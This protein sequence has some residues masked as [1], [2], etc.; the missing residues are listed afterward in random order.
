MSRTLLWQPEQTMPVTKTEHEITW[1]WAG[2]T[3]RVGCDRSGA[4][5][6]ILLLPALSSISTR[7]EMRPLQQRLAS[8][9]TTTSVDWPGFGDWP[10]PPVDW[11]P[12]A[13]A[14]FLKYV[15]TDLVPKPFATIAAGHAACYVMAQSA[16]VPGSTGRLCLIAPTW[17]GPLPTMMGKRHTAFRRI[18]RAFDHQFVGPLLYTLNVNRF[19]VRAMARGHVYSDPNWLTGSR[20]AEKLAVTRAVGARHA[21][22]RFVAGELDFVRSRAEFLAL[23]GRIADT[24]LVVFADGTPSRSKAEMEALAALP[25]VRLSRIVSGKLAVH[26]E[27]PDDVTN[28]IGPFLRSDRLE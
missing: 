14:A 22:V 17:R 12:D 13:Y 16:A 25:N 11:R 9:F 10:K 28:A 5:P 21:S 19:V 23:A 3:I 6:S 4:G 27:C 15:V 18:V 26:E 24:I 1:T 20:L 2:N 8:Q 7:R